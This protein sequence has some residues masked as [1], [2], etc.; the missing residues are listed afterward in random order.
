V[1]DSPRFEW[2]GLLIDVC[3]LFQS[4]STVKTLLDSVARY[5]L[6][7]L[8]FHLT[9]DQGWRLESKAF[10]LLTSVGSVRDSSSVRFA[11]DEQDGVQYGPHCYTRSTHHNIPKSSFQDK[12]LHGGLPHD[13]AS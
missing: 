4:V 1:R 10:P 6:N 3:L 7:R 9:D 11:R 2:R 5:T 12:M 13:T 8:H